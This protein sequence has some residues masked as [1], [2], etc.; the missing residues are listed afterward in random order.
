ML[1]TYPS[2]V[3]SFTVLQ[4]HLEDTFVQSKVQHKQ[5]FKEPFRYW[6]DY[7]FFRWS[8]SVSMER[9]MDSLDF[10]TENNSF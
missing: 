10:D 5:E 9:Q 4:F 1:I 3:S 7:S 8:S 2:S 6:Y